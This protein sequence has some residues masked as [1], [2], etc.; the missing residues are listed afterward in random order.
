MFGKIKCSNCG[1]ENDKKSKFCSACG[2]PLSGITCSSCGELVGPSYKFC[3]NCGARIS[4]YDEQRSGAT[5]VVD[6]K[7][8]ISVW[9][10]APSDFA[11]RFEVSDIKGL[12]SKKLTVMPGTKALFLQG[13][14]FSGELPPGT[15]TVGGLTQAIKTLNLAGKATVIL[16]DDSDVALDFSIG[17]LR[18]K[19]NFDAGVKGRIVANT[20][21]PIMFFN[22]LMKGREHVA[23]SEVQGLLRN[24]MLNVLQSKL[25]QYS[26]EELYGNLELKRELGQDFEHELSTTLSRVGVKLIHMP[27]FDYDESYW[28]EI[29]E[30]Q[31]KLGRAVKGE[32]LEKKRS[33]LVK[34]IRARLTED[35]IDELRNAEDL[36]K[37]MHEIDKDELIRGNEMSELKQIFM[38]NQEDRVFARE[39]MFKRLDVQNDVELQKMRTDYERE[40]D[41]EDARSGIRILKEMKAAKRE[42]AA[43]YQAL[44][45]EKQQKLAE[46]EAERLKARST[47][48][49]ESLISMTEGKQ[50]E[51][52]AELAR[53][54]KGKALTDEQILALAAGDSAAVAEAFKEKYKSLSAE[55]IMKVYEGQLEDKDEL[56]QTIQEISSRGDDRLERMASKALEQMGVT[57]ATRAQGASSG[58]TTV[59]TGGGG[60]PVIVGGAPQ[61]SGSSAQD[62]KKVVICPECNAELPLGTRFCTNCGATIGKKE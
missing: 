22:N 8:K 14:R 20:E 57:A 37:F 35:K 61:M 31:G 56:V 15:Y 25:K 40:R 21:E 47:V 10:R 24:E 46:I 43:G 38:E 45:L 19:E 34:Q 51:Y 53:M 1:A 49:A 11:Q 7:G 29:I 55:Q 18:T 62:V 3:P 39:W 4:D 16:V 33:E 36:E 13:G 12:F 9:Q 59:V 26:F 23:V 2:S 41:E 44:D 50:A 48:S 27:Y 5:P 28:T 54:E 58:A 6:E 52:L 42:D 60:A 30:K 17:G 32:E